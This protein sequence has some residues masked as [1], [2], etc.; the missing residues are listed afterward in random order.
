MKPDPDLAF[1]DQS[2]ESFRIFSFQ[3]KF[4]NCD[5]I[6]LRHPRR[7]FKIQEKSPFLI[8]SSTPGL[9]EIIVFT[10]QNKNFNIFYF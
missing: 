2:G 5:L 7:Y 4:D 10:V 9:I 8:S 6:F 3:G 1:E